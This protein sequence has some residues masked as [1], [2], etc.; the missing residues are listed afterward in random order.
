MSLSLSANGK[1]YDPVPAGSYRAVCVWVIDL[2]TQDTVYQGVRK[3]KHQVLL[4][5][6]LA[7]ELMEDGRP[8]VL[9]RTFTASLHE[10]AGLR[11]FLDGWRGRKFTEQELEGFD[12]KNILGKPALVSVGHNESGD[13]IYA[14]LNAA[15]KLPKGMTAP[16]KTHNELVAF[17]CDMKQIPAGLPDWIKNKIRQSAEF[18]AGEIYDAPPPETK[19]ASGID[20]VDQAAI[21]AVNDDIPF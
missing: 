6:E 20:A 10:N 2:G 3:A 19:A 4:T 7:D 1:H 12:L 21:N 8:F 14:N 18:Q 11:A 16:E 9:S 15:V 5:F 17:D 13:R